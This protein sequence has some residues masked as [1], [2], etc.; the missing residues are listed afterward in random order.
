[1]RIAI[2]RAQKEQSGYQ[3][4]GLRRSGYEALRSLK[5]RQA[6]AAI[7]TQRARLGLAGLLL[8]DPAQGL[9]D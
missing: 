7:G 8:R 3:V 6:A 4:L 1:M 5:P 9:A 2:D